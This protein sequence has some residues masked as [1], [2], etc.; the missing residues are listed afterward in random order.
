MRTVYEWLLRMHPPG[1][2]HRFAAE[3]LCIYDEASAAS[4]SL[5]LLA[6]ALGSLARQWLL[7][8]GAWKAAAIVAGALLQVICG[9]LIWLAAGPAPR[10]YHGDAP[11]MMAL[12]RLIV[13]LAGP[14]V[15]MVT[16][17][18]LWVR[19]FTQRRQGR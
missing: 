7:R 15:L 18:S 4:G 11:G 16:G 12:F 13:W 9:G 14:V 17:A 5:P 8:S 10:A 2:R 6:D 19:Q 3:M 1:F